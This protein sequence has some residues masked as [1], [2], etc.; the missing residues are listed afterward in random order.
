[1]SVCVWRGR[2][3]DGVQAWGPW[4]GLGNLAGGYACER[5][6]VEAERGGAAGLFLLSSNSARPTLRDHTYMPLRCSAWIAKREGRQWMRKV[7]SCNPPS[8]EPFFIYNTRM[9]FP[10]FPRV[11]TAPLSAGWRCTTGVGIAPAGESDA[12]GPFRKPRMRSRRH[13]ESLF[14]VNTS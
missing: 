9:L 2:D 12:M 7:V 5:A 3:D 13:P 1:M 6:V 4:P 11:A 10:V 14:R 8:L